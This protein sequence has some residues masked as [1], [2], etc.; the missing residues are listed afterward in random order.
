[1]AA[2]FAKLLAA[3]LSLAVLAP[4]FGQ[5]EEMPPVPEVPREFRGAWVATVENIDWPTAPGLPP[6]QQRAEADAILD[7][8]AEVGLNVI[9]LQVRP[10]A[11]ALY[12]S[13]LEPW[14]YYLT[15]E[16][17]KAPEPYYD[18]LTHWIDGAH[19]RGIELHVWLNPYRVKPRNAKFDP[20][21]ESI[22]QQHPEAVVEY[23]NET[24]MQMWMDPASE[25]AQQQTLAVFADL[26]ER[27]DLDGVHMDDY[28]YPY[29]VADVPFPDEKSFEAY[30]AAGGELAL[31]DFRRNNVNT[32]VEQIYTQTKDLKPHV[33]VGISPFG[34]WRPGFP[35][36]VRGFDQYDRLYADAK[37]WLNEGWVDYWTPQL[38]WSTSA[39]QQ[40]FPALLS[41]WASENTQD[42]TLAPG[43]YTSRLFPGVSDWEPEEIAGQIYIGRYGQGDGHVH[44]S[45]KT[46]TQN[47]KA[48]ADVLRDEAYVRPAAVPAMTWIDD[49]APPAPEVEAEVVAAEMIPEPA[50]P[51]PLPDH[52]FFEPTTKPAATPTAAAGVKLTLPADEDVKQYAVWLLENDR[53]N[54]TLLPGNT[55]ETF[56]PATTEPTAIAVR[57]LNRLGVESEPTVIEFAT[58]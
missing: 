45:M 57:A 16:Q 46:I 11:D 24:R 51:T 6:E 29:P 54:V 55:T 26:V 19:D 9:V 27:Y 21:P 34:I 15:G 38:Y 53:W 23:G 1:M 58:E 28:F 48:M 12:D 42:R 2:P 20:G 36:S 13:P 49:A 10:A 41:W 3:S 56:L 52:E 35:E 44:F 14:S 47:L 37:L 32:L 50:A 17:G 7:R 25:V 18:P 4:A 40:S 22:A 30:Q 43:L 33:K 39:P 8:A 5:S 31:N